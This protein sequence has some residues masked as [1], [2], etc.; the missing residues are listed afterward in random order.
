[1]TSDTVLLMLSLAHG[2]VAFFLAYLVLKGT[3]LRFYPAGQG[4]Q[5]APSLSGL[6]AAAASVKR[7][8]RAVRSRRRNREIALQW[9]FLLE[10]MSFAALSGLD[11]N[12]AFQAASKRTRGALREEV[13]KVVVRIMG[14]MSL[15]TALA[16]MEKD[17]VPEATRLR[18][19]LAQA[20]M[21]GTPV[22][23]V[24]ETLASE[25]HTQES[26]EFEERL[27]A[28]P[29]KLSIITVLFLLPPVLVISVAP[30]ILS[31]LGSRW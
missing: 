18:A 20:E 30:H 12:S 6:A 15:G 19:M 22:S 23:Q 26:Q 9:P 29:V 3:Q 10:A 2:F 24:L 14:G 11:L 28:L 25:Y 1:M 27:N 31:F 17:G 8:A 13:D 4:R 21:L 7:I 5:D 16:V